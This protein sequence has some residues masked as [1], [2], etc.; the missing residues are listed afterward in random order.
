MHSLIRVA[1]DSV[2][3]N[4]KAGASVWDALAT[5]G[6][7]NAALGKEGLTEAIKAEV[8]AYCEACPVPD[9]NPNTN[10]TWRVYRKLIAD[11]VGYSVA[12]LTPEGDTR[13][14][15]DVRKD[16]KAA[17]GPSEPD[18]EGEGG[19]EGGEGV[20]APGTDWDKLSPAE[21]I[22]AACAL[23]VAEFGKLEAAQ[24]EEAR[25]RIGMLVAL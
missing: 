7:E 18:A 11:A 24:F 2:I 3:V 22:E 25:A 1:L 8:A 19:G 20:A 14:V 13:S 5:Y 23:I 21:K 15:A 9:F 16:V 12:L 4:N 17:K 6:A 10:S